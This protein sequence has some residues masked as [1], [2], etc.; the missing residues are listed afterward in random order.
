MTFRATIAAACADLCADLR[1]AWQ[2]LRADVRGP[3]RLMIW[4]WQLERAVQRELRIIRL[5]KRA[6]R[7]K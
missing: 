5:L 7:A 6:S 4:H 1:L 3:L 2:Q